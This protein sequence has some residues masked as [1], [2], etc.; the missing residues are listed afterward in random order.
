MM[1]VW[2]VILFVN[3]TLAVGLGL[4]YAGWGRRSE[5][6]ERELEAVRDRR[7]R[8]AR[9]DPADATGG[10]V[11][12]VEVAPVV[13]GE[14]ERL[15]QGRLPRRPAVPGRAGLARP[16][17]DLRLAGLGVV[18]EDPAKQ[19]VGDVDMPLGV[20]REVVGELEARHS[21]SGI[22][23]TRLRTV[24]GTPGGDKEHDGEPDPMHRRS[25]TGRAGAVTGARLRARA[26]ARA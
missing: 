1:P 7:D 18:A 6:L 5:G 4:G 15:L 9:V 22:L 23:L 2:Q 16:R 24:P 8:P 13:E 3:L 14:A 17:H 20:D 10:E 26:R 11:D 21:G 19:A 25:Y 12:D